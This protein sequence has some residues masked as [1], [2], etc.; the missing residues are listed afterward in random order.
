MR[1]DFFRFALCLLALSAAFPLAAQNTVQNAP[2][3]LLRTNTQAV[4]I[5]V[6]VSKANDEPVLSLHR[7]DFQVL[8]DGKPQTIDLFEEHSAPASTPAAA[9][10]KLPPNLY[11]NQPSAPQSD[12]VNVLLLDSLNTDPQDQ[13]AIHK[14]IA[15][16]L[17]TMQPGTQ[18]AIFTL[19]SK[20][21]LVQGF[22]ADTSMLHAAMNNKKTEVSPGSIV[23]SQSRQDDADEN[24]QQA[25]MAMSGAKDAGGPALIQLKA[26][27]RASLTLQALEQLARYLAGVPGRKN[28]IWF[29][30][31]FPV[32]I[33]PTVKEQQSF[34]RSFTFKGDVREAAG[35]LT[36]S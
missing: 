12:A 9:P 22:T 20:L 35:L 16:F 15:N 17:D 30:S 23:A 10:L 26:S 11:T 5:D 31:T 19:G 4:S 34:N 3:P 13:I 21:Q 29:A 24:M 28:L 2:A 8:E 33:F 27:D 6:V 14:Q 1:L 7:Q 32:S 25:L 36:A 18:I